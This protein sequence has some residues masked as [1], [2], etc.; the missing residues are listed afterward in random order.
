MR[1]DELPLR[2]R[3]LL[4]LHSIFLALGFD[5]D[6]LFAGLLASGAT[7]VAIRRNDRTYNFHATDGDEDGGDER[8]RKK[9]AKLVAEVADP[10]TAG[11]ANRD[12]DEFVSE[13]A[14]ATA[15]WNDAPAVNQKKLVETSTIRRHA[16]AIVAILVDEGLLPPVIVPKIHELACPYC[17]KKIA[18]NSKNERGPFV[19]AHSHPPCA[20]FMT[21]EPTEFLAAVNRLNTN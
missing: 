5:P 21:L 2:C 9:S 18:E 12:L 13:W 17:G 15:A 4:A 3:E 16:V 10:K 14:R 1:L 19:V 7:Y 11:P 6:D 8:A 20:E